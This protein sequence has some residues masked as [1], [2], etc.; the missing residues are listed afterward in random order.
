MHYNAAMN[1]CPNIARSWF[2]NFSLWM[3]ILSGLAACH[4]VPS[5]YVD[6]AE[7][8]ITLTALTTSPQQ[9]RDKV[10]ILGGVLVKERQDGGRVWLQLK[11]RP[12]DGRYQPHRPISL[13]GPEAGYFWV[14]AANRE[15]LP[16][17]YRDWARMTVVGRVIGTTES[18][19]AAI[20]SEPVLMLMYVRGW[21]TSGNNDDAWE[22]SYDPAYLPTI[23]QGLN[24][25]F[26][27]Q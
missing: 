17:H 26:Q 12:L 13:D 20:E 3:L 21:S 4:T 6:Q 19:P 7:P 22:E 27:T 5:K 18:K 11:N 23:P 24:G 2:K 25:E 16:A 8:G 9:F 15:Q 1:S 10:V 14:T